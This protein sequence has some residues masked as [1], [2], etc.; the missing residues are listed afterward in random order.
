MAGFV[1]YH[2]RDLASPARRALQDY[3]TVI[4]ENPEAHGISIER[5]DCLDG[6]VPTLIVEPDS[7]SVVG[8]RGE[9]LRSQTKAKGVQLSEHGVI[10]KTVVLL[11]GRNGRKEDLL[12]VAER[13]CAVGLRCVLIDMP[14]HGDSPV[15]LVKFGADEW[16]QDLPRAVLLECAE[17]FQFSADHAA[18]WG[19]SMGGS[20]ANSA[21]ADPKH[22]HTWSSL[23]IVCSFDSLQSVLEAQSH[24]SFLTDCVS[25][26]CQS[27]GGAD[28]SQVS[29]ALWVKDVTTPVLVVHGKEDQL[30]P[31]DNGKNLYHSYASERKRWIQVAEGNHSNILITPMPLYAEM[32]EWILQR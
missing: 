21:V 24:S 8:K 22:G 32:A 3:H 28:I 14:A 18:L 16:E 17:K 5:L 26:V 29:P 1:I 13:F 4:L 23:T 12:P 7:Q 9:L 6:K 20:F 25:K 2:G 27:S 30:I 15:Q 10:V 31:S 19:M 11:H